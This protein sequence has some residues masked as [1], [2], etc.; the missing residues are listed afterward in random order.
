VG[1]NERVVKIAIEKGIGEQ[2]QCFWGEEAIFGTDPFGC[3]KRSHAN[4]H[5]MGIEEG[6]RLPHYVSDDTA[7]HASLLGNAQDRQISLLQRFFTMR[8]LRST[9]GG[10]FK[11]KNSMPASFNMI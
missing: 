5:L 2:C 10:S 3:L 4:E 8:A 6:S 7:V 11:P 1:D 9:D